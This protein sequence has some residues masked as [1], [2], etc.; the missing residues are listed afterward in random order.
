MSQTATLSPLA[1]SD[2]NFANWQ[3]ISAHLAASSL[4]LAFLEQQ[5]GQ[6][7]HSA[8]DYAD[9]YLQDSH[10]ESFSL[11]GGKIRQGSFHR[12]QG[13]GVRAVSGE[14][15]GFACADE[16]SAQALRESVASARSIARLG[17]D[18]QVRLQQQSIPERY[19]RQHRLDGLDDQAKVQLLMQIDHYARAAD[20]RV[21]EVFA[22]LSAAS[23]LVVIA[24][25]DGTWAFD[26]RPMVHC[27]V[28]VLVEENGRR[29][30]G[31]SG[32]GGRQGYDFFAQEGLVKHYAEEAVRQAL[33]NLAAIPAPAGSL[34]VVLGAGWAGILLHEAVG[35]GL[36]GDF[37]RKG[38]SLYSN[39]L[40]EKVA[41]ELCTVVDD[42][43]LPLRRGSLNVDDEGTPAQYNV[44]IEN[45]ILKGYLQDKLNARLMG[46][47]ATGNSRRQSYA[48]LPMPRMTNTYLLGGTRHPNELIE[49]VDKGIY[50]VNFSG[51]QVDIT[52]GNFVFSA[53]EAYL[54]ENGRITTP[55]KGATLIG[56][57]PE[58]LTKVSMVA[59]DFA[60]DSGVG[61]CGKEGQSVPVGVGQPSMKIDHITVGGTEV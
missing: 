44:L 40:G 30:S 5:L 43:T 2:K 23:S 13:L 51:G 22:S 31:R 25:S 14:K 56:N 29:E 52:N 28:S 50:A 15:S 20:P 4:D 18:T 47:A 8:I 58:V 9:I 26:V 34:P 48:H 17:Q 53:S 12:G 57:G 19:P 46:M 60:L 35:H 21:K 11:E 33:V 6:L 27:S 55:I 1:S 16:W 54:I 32:G 24:A 3:S 41:S 39:R 45:G 42:G 49:S 61:T 38:S 37:N 10:S 36:E 59:N 7:Q